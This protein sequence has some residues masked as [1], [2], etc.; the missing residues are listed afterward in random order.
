M[1]A[2]IFTRIEIKRLRGR[3][4]S[5]IAKHLVRMEEEDPSPETI[6]ALKEWREILRKIVEADK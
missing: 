2:I 3:V 5:H 6:L 1:T 4:A